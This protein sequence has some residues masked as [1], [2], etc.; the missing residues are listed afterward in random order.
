MKCNECNNPKTYAKG[1]CRSCWKRQR[2]HTNPEKYK[3]QANKWK[4][5]NKQHLKEY[6]KEYW[7]KNKEKQNAKRRGDPKI[8]AAR[9]KYY[10]EHKEQELANKKKYDTKNKETV[11]KKAREYY[12]KNPEL[13]RSKSRSWNKENPGKVAKRNLKYYH[14]HY[15]NDELFKL[16][17]NIR[18]ALYKSLKKN[19]LE[20]TNSTFKML[21]YTK[22][23]LKKHLEKQ[24]D[25]T[26]AWKNYGLVWH[27]DHIKPISWA[28][29]KEEIIEYNQLKN[30]QPLDAI[31]NMKKSNHFEG[32][33]TK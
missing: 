22:Q 21:G 16:Q 25:E 6:T 14:E 29:T 28:K 15:K 24:F 7:G 1:L 8:L 32:T 18:K 5:K 33:P 19:N 30:L 27:V 10:Y 9:R 3:A 13:A 2:Y 11:N 26:M 12:W 4:A 31:L 20:K 23:Q 17:R